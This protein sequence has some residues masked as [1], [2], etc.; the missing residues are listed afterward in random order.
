MGEWQARLSRHP[1]GPLLRGTF[2]FGYDVEVV[3]TFPGLDLP[4]R[5]ST[6][7]DWKELQKFDPS[8]YP[9]GGVRDPSGICPQFYLPDVLQEL[10]EKAKTSKRNWN[11]G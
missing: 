8:D 3:P 11:H 2:T 10:R 6:L 7:R 9:S 1:P 5:P 4:V